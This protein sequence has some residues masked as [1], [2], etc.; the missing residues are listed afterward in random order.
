MNPF[1]SK[2]FNCFIILTIDLVVGSFM[3]FS[4]Y[5][6]KFA[7]LLESEQLCFS[8]FPGLKWKKYQKPF[9]ISQVC[10]KFTSQASVKKNQII[11][12]K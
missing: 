10:E 11:N 2:P 5:C 4:C 3:W 8:I 6:L 1:S 7:A 12:N 9:K